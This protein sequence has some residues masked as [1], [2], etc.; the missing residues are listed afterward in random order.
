MQTGL[1]GPDDL[2]TVLRMRWFGKRIADSDMDLAN[3]G[4]IP[5]VG[6][7]R[8]AP[9]YDML[10]MGYAPLSGGELPPQIAP[11]FALSLPVERQF[12]L[13][14]CG[15]AIA[16]WR[17]AGGDERISAPFRAVCR[18][19]PGLPDIVRQKAGTVGSFRLAVRN[20]RGRG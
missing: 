6:R 7:F 18:E 11:R 14:A 2:E 13:D 10:P 19:N 1:L 17:N 9:A 12:W 4:L 8:I 20:G 16:F 3:L 15:C 5:D